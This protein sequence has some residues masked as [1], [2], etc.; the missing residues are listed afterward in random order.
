MLSVFTFEVKISKFE[1]KP[2]AFISN[3]FVGT[4]HILGIG[5]RIGRSKD[6]ALPLAFRIHYEA[7]SFT[8]WILQ[9]WLRSSKM[10]LS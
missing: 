1:S 10:E 3:K 4:K 5:T 8:S 6:F 9:S 2:L 7:A